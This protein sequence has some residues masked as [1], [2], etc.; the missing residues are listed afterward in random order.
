MHH[1]LRCACGTVSGSVAV[2]AAR[3]RAICYCRDCQSYAYALGAADAVLDAD[4]GS[5]VVPTLQ[6]T[7]RIERGHDA[8]AC[9]SLSERGLLRW[10]AQCCTTPLG[11]TP[12]DRRLS[13]LGLLHTCLARSRAEL[14]AVFGAARMRVNTQWAKTPVAG[15]PF[16]AVAMVARLAPS[17]VRA[18]F[19]GSFRQSPFFDGEG[20]P[21]ARV[22]VL[23]ATEHDAAQRQVGADAR[24]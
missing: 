5:D 2:A 13:Y 8:I 9:L 19:S 21:I 18:R 17:L 23:S 7:V 24:R 6:E 20:R 4:G 22:R 3:G 11:N 1:P 14:D 12:R 16:T 10:Y 15:T